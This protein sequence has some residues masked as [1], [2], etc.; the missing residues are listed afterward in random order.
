MNTTVTINLANTFFYMD[1]DAFKK[2]RN[3]LKLIKKSFESEEGCEE[4]MSDIETR[5]AKLF[6]SKLKHDRQVIGVLEVDEIISI[7]GQPEDYV[8]GEGTSKKDFESKEDTITM[9]KNYFEMV[10]M[11]TLVVSFLDWGIMWV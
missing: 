6:T 8:W 4:I 11:F 3:Y 1:E 2:L 7:M 9:K 10:K 5:I